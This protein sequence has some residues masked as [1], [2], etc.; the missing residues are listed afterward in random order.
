MEFNVSQ[1]FK[2]L[3]NSIT[4]TIYEGILKLGYDTGHNMSIYY[5]LDLLNHLLDTSFQ[6]NQECITYLMDYISEKNSESE[7]CLIFPENGRFKF[8]VTNL[9]IEQI[10]SQYKHKPFLKELVD[11][12][13]THIFSVDDIYALFQKY[14][15]EFVG[16]KVDHSEFQYVFYFNDIQF[17]EYKYCFNFDEIGGYY[18]RLLDYDFDK[19]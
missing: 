13:R 12:V 5:D 7:T 17:D 1:R 3:D 15:T 6:T 19:L 9:G 10:L 14:S 2:R 8:T 4:S 16:E 18:H 11:L